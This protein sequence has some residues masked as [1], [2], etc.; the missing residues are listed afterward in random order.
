MDSHAS[1]RTLVPMGGRKNDTRKP[2]IRGTSWVWVWLDAD[3]AP[4]HQPTLQGFLI[5][6]HRRTCHDARG[7]YGEWWFQVLVQD[8]EGAEPFA[9]WVPEHQIRR[10]GEGIEP[11]SWPS[12]NT[13]TFDTVAERRRRRAARLG[14]R[15]W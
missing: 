11:P 6:E 4:L 9:V 7:E 10:A 8:R 2:R 5:R 1:N 15:T 12:D 3:R 13:T 14:G